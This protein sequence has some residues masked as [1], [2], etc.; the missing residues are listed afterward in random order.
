[1]RDPNGDGCK[2][3]R[4][5]WLQHLVVKRFT[6]SCSKLKIPG[7]DANTAIWSYNAFQLGREEVE[8]VRV[9]RSRG[10]KERRRQ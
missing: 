6:L 5:Q 7:K 3:A 10:E 1:M 8:R 9:G 2:E 4:G